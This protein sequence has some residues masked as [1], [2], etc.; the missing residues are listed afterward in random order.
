MVI[1]T[2]RHCGSAD[3]FWEAVALR[4]G[5]RELREE[6]LKKSG[7]IFFSLFCTWT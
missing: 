3:I 5:E 1:V 2:G 6:R 7:Q 4:E